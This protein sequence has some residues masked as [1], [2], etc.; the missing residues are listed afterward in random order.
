MGLFFRSETPCN[1]PKFLKPGKIVIVLQGRYAG[2]KAVIVKNNDDGTADRKYPHAILAGID[3]YP[4]KV[5][6]SMSKKKI[7]RRSRIKP[8]V[9]TIN[10]NHIMPTRYVLKDVNLKAVVGP[11]ALDKGQRKETRKQ[12][13]ALFEEKYKNTNTRYFFQKL[14]F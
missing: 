6:K 5:N 9:K 2:R 1:M 13:K 14:R 7:A 3:R 11:N 12:V 10:Y 8:F 4:L